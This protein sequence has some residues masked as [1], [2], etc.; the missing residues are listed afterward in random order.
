MSAIDTRNLNR[1]RL[2]MMADVR[3]DGAAAAERVKVRNL[4]NGGM[5]VEGK[6]IARPGQRV[7]AHIGRI[8][9]VGG[10]VAWVQSARIGIAFDEMID[11]KMA[12]TSLVGDM[13]EAP[14]Y[15]RPAVTPCGQTFTVRKV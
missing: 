1:D 5:M 11:A 12:R 4:S 8:G 6:L 10:C 15:A 9:D 7:V 13:A 2:L 14:R 3:L